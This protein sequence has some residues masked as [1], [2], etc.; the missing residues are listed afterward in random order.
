MT[1]VVT[2]TAVQTSQEDT[3]ELARQFEAVR[4]DLSKDSNQPTA[5]ATTPVD[6]PSLDSDLEE[7][8]DTNRFYDEVE[9]EDMEYDPATEVSTSPFLLLC[10]IGSFPLGRHITIRAPVAIDSRSRVPPCATE[11][12]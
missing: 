6:Q 5:A 11:R 3:S 12:M 7:E 10:L 1:S 4:I 8:D 9:I 2:I